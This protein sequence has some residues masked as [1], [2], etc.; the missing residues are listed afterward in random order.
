MNRTELAGQL[1][2]RTIRAAQ[3]I[4]SSHGNVERRAELRMIRQQAAICVNQTASCEASA[5]GRLKYTRF[6]G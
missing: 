6:R 3:D 4:R 2:E 1:R 5:V